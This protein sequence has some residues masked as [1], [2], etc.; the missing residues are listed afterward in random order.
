MRGV[1]TSSV[2]SSSEAF[3]DRRSRNLD[4]IALYAA[5]DLLVSVD[6]IVGGVWRLVGLSP[7][8]G[9]LFVKAEAVED[10]RILFSIS[11]SSLSSASA[12]AMA[13]LLQ[14]SLR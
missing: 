13:D 12:L 7:V 4:V 11:L 14:A 3:F 1:G 10:A 6:E 8:L 2:K 9:L 5:P